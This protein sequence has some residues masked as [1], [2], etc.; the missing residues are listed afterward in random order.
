MV[1]HGFMVAARGGSP[2]V[3]TAGLASKCG[4]HFAM[5]EEDACK[6]QSDQET[7]A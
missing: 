1:T 6:E 4:H 3:R 2:A 5:D 7:K